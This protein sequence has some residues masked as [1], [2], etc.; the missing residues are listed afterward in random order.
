M[1]IS[2]IACFCSPFSICVYSDHLPAH[3]SYATIR[4]FFLF[5]SMRT[6]VDCFFQLFTAQKC[7]NS[8]PLHRSSYR[9]FFLFHFRVQLCF[10]PSFDL[11]PP[12]VL[13]TLFWI[14]IWALWFYTLLTFFFTRV[15]FFAIFPFI[16][17]FTMCSL[18][19]CNYMP[20][21]EIFATSF[22]LCFIFFFAYD[23]FVY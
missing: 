8:R 18:V 19:S 3:P 22:S 12:S 20:F 13:G 2:S 1:Y 15:T 4:C 16:Q 17:C 10:D 11:F 9:H 6:L 21:I 7:S 5:S 23:G 14:N